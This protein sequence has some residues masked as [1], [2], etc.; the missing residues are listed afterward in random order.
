MS[1][2]QP[3]VDRPLWEPS[4]HHAKSGQPM[5]YE[6]GH[7]YLLLTY[8]A[9]SVTA[10]LAQ[11]MWFSRKNGEWAGWGQQW[12]QAFAA[13]DS[14]KEMGLLL[15]PPFTGFLRVLTGMP[16]IGVAGAIDPGPFYRCGC[17]NSAA[18]GKQLLFGHTIR[19]LL[20]LI[21]LC[22]ELISLQQI[23]LGDT[24]TRSEHRGQHKCQSGDF[25]DSK[26]CHGRQTIALIIPGRYKL[27]PART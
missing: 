17:D 1:A 6:T 26:T 5:C 12:L 7:F 8:P 3:V 15:L 27:L 22:I 19:L 2:A 9:Y 20:R 25:C 13:C 11:Q 18:A 14:Q 23:H 10:T 16:N 24:A 21:G 4:N